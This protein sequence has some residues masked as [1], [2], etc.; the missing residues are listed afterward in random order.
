MLDGVLDQVGQGVFEECCFYGGCGF[1]IVCYGDGY[2]GVIQYEF[3]EIY[4]FLYCFGDLYWYLGGGCFVLV[5][6]CQEQYVVDDGMDVVQLFQ[7]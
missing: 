5:G 1:Q 6:M 7:V 4:G 2:V 3:E